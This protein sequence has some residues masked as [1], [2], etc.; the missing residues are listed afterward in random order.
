[1]AQ[2]GVKVIDLD[3]SPKEPVMSL[4]FDDLGLNLK[5]CVCVCVL[6]IN[7]DV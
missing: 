7:L 5:V 3:L 2:S 1:M 6:G 4:A